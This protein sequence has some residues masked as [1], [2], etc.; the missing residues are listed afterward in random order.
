[1]LRE[2]FKAFIRK[3]MPGSRNF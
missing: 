3:R 2:I 1:M